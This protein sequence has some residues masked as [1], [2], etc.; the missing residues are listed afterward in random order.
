VICTSSNAEKIVNSFPKDTPIV[1]APDRHLGAW[2]EKK[3]GRNLVKWP[4]F[5][6]V[7]EQ[8]TERQL[9]KL[10]VRHPEAKL[11]AHPECEASVLA[12]ADFVG[13]TRGLLEYVKTSPAKSFIVATEVGILHLMSKARPDAELIRRRR[14]AAAIAASALT[15]VSTR[16]KSCT[17][18]C[19]TANRRSRSRRTCACAPS[20]RWSA[21]WRSPPRAFLSLRGSGGHSV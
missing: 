20:S 11:I 14:A 4:G 8:F 3:T 6:I 1:F 15:C 13:S 16:W 10:K 18:A 12:L 19:G 5:C 7:H 17:C 9:Q 21:C 2:V